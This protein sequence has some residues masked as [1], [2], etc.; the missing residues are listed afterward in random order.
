MKNQFANLFL[1]ISICSIIATFSL[2][3]LITPQKTF[4][5]SENKVLQALPSISL[6]KLASGTYSTQL[7]GYFSDQIAFR[8]RLVSLKATTELARGC[9][10]S[11]GIMLGKKNYLIENYKYTDKNYSF[12]QS[13]L[14]KIEGLIENL[15]KNGKTV[16]SVI[17]PRKT[18]VAV[19][20]LPD[21]Y[22]SEQSDSV[23]K[24]VTDKH[25][26]LLP[27]LTEAESKGACTY[28]RT[29]H[30]WTA[31]GAYAAYCELS[32]LIGYEPFDI[33]YFALTSLS[34]FF[35][36]TTYSKSGIFSIPPE[37]IQAPSIDSSS[38]LTTVMDT[39]ISFSGLYD[40]SYL[41][42]KDKYSVFLG[43]NH[44]HIKITDT[45]S[46]DKPTLVLI[47]DSFSHSLA[48]YL[49][50]HFNLELIDPRYFNGSI[51]NYLTENDFKNIL[52]IF[53]LETLASSNI[54]IR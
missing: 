38:F 29:D 16:F 5:E 17:V 35:Y 15:N 51:V 37:T 25:T 53:G 3:Y 40:T 12:L 45:V 52:F 48:P 42:I 21:S 6:K 47:K 41:A 24:R 30:H 23:W 9:A 19:K 44:A 46:C 4:S 26:S 7:H 8:S 49:V 11:N 36:G 43:G 2:S 39:G 1:L 33:E 10:E 20:Y 50:H 34:D 13:N 54:A 28:Y 22:K 31:Q 14:S 32:E 27:C 18:D